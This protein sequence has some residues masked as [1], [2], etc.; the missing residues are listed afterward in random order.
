MSQFCNRF[1]P[2]LAVAF[3]S[4]DS[5]DG[6][7]EFTRGLTDRAAGM[8]GCRGDGNLHNELFKVRDAL[9]IIQIQIILPRRALTNIKGAVDAI[10]IREVDPTREGIDK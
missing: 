5:P 10:D 8:G 4:K 6:V 7:L 9:D 3:L 2:A 1:T